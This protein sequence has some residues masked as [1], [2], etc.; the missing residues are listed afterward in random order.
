MNEQTV[1][2]ARKRGMAVGEAAIWCNRM[3]ERTKNIYWW[4]VAQRIARRELKTS[5]VC[6]NFSRFN[7]TAACNSGTGAN[8][9]K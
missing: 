5:V 6:I 8:E 9:R 2:V 7:T 4:R 3:F 1:K